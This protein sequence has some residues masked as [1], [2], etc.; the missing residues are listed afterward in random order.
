[1]RPLTPEGELLAN[2]RQTLK[3]DEM[4]A[5]LLD[6]VKAR[7]GEAL[8]IDFVADTGDDR[9]VSQAVAR[10]VFGEFVVSEHG[11]DGESADVVLPRGDMLVFGGDTAY[12]VA[13]AEEISSRRV[14]ASLERS[15]PRRAGG[16]DLDARLARHPGQPRLVRRARTG[17][18]RL[19]RRTARSDASARK[20]EALRP[21]D[22]RRAARRGR[23]VGLV[24]RSL[25]L[26]E[27][28]GTLR[29]I[30]DAAKQTVVA[31]FR[32]IVPSRGGDGW[33]SMATKRSKSRVTGRSR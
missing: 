9:D 4:G 18:G 15:A 25:Y 31:F 23:N 2:A 16:A 5:T 12:P 22:A 7:G 21:G 32:G 30:A 26:D 29:M 8:W 13:T 3:L 20:S 28:G 33:R 10:M 1:M 17:F 24:A 14:V 27:V 6:A 19:F 11:E